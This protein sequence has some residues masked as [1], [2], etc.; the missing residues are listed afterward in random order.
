MYQSH[1]QEF[2]Y[3]GQFHIE[4]KLPIYRQLGNTYPA[5][6]YARS[7]QVRIDPD[8]G[9][10]G[11]FPYH[12]ISY[13]IRLPLYLHLLGLVPCVRPPSLPAISVFQIELVWPT[14]LINMH[15]RDDLYP[16]SYL[17]LLDS[18]VFHQ[19]LQFL[20]QTHGS[21]GSKVH[22]TQQKNIKS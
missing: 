2:L 4:P 5:L 13:D 20:P 10:N 19:H 22:L 7:D 3:C 1:P 14:L 21:K 12:V 17:Q 11:S 15:N 16:F 8:Y 9:P 18:L 6:L